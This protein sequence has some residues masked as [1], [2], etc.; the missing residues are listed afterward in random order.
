MKNSLQRHVTKLPIKPTENHVY[1]SEAEFEPIL[2][3]YIK[4]FCSNGKLNWK[5]TQLYWTYTSMSANELGGKKA[6][7]LP[8]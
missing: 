4:L 2:I 1:K 6:N 7:I 8:Y 5:I 3:Q